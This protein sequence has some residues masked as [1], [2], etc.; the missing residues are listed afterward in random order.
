MPAPIGV[1][2]IP[3]LPGGWWLGKQ[4]VETPVISSWTARCQKLFKYW[5]LVSWPTSNHI[6]RRAI[7]A[8]HLGMVQQCLLLVY[9]LI[10]CW[11]EPMYHGLCLQCSEAHY[12]MIAHQYEGV[13]AL[14]ILWVKPLS[15]NR[16]IIVLN[17]C[18]AG[19][20]GRLLLPHYTGDNNNG[21]VD[22]LVMLK[23]M[24]E[25]IWYQTSSGTTKIPIQFT[26]RNI[27]V[28]SVECW[29]LHTYNWPIKTT[30]RGDQQTYRI[31]STLYTLATDWTSVLLTGPL[32]CIH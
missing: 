14:M 27:R 3:A 29:P 4:V 18:Q 9:L 20:T 1:L 15:F 8:I 25:S 6:R 23:Y 19:W 5:V 7:Y 31:A 26:T 10:S 22:C 11:L 21:C 17:H 13:P 32:Y 12:Q 2:W 16:F 24:E 30:L 28:Q